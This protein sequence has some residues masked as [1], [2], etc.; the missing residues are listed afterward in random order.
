MENNTTLEVIDKQ[1]AKAIYIWLKE[2]GL[3]K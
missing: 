2:K 3:V 1:E